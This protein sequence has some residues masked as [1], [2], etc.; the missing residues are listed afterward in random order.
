M[1]IFALVSPRL[2]QPIWSFSS[3]PA[4]LLPRKSPTPL[5]WNEIG[6]PPMPGIGRDKSPKNRK[7]YLQNNRFTCCE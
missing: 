7:K 2:L 1:A 6:T 3:T 4:S 5:T